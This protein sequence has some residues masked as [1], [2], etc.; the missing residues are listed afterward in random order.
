MWLPKLPGMAALLLIC[1]SAAG[2][3][4][5]TH[6]FL[7]FK[8][9]WNKNKKNEFVI[10]GLA[11]STLSGLPSGGAAGNPGGSITIDPDGS[12]HPHTGAADSWNKW[13]D[14]AIQSEDG[15]IQVL[16][17]PRENIEPATYHFYQTLLPDAQQRKQQLQDYKID[18][19]KDM[20]MGEKPAPL[21]PAKTLADVVG[22]YCKQARPDYDQVMNFYKDHIKGHGNDLNSPPPP[23]FEYSCYACD[24]NL[25]KVYDTTIEHY[26]RDFLHPE[27]NIIRK[28][29]DILH[30]MAL[31]GL[32]PGGGVNVDLYDALFY[33]NK[34]DPSGSGACAYL[35]VSELYQ[36]V[37]ETLH[38]LY[39][40]AEKL[41][42]TNNKNFKAASAIIR[43]YITV[44]R[45][46]ELLSGSETAFS[47]IQ[48]E[49]A[50]LIKRNIDF[51]FD[52]FK[53]NDWRTI[54]NIPFILS[55]YREEGMFNEGNDQDF[56]E[57]LPQLQ[58]ICN[59]FKLSIE[60]DIKIGQNG[61]Y[62]LAHVKGDCHIMPYFMQ[63]SNQCYKWVVA[64]EDNLDGLG[65][66]KPSQKQTIDCQLI[67]NELI[68]PPNAPKPVYIGTRKYTTELRSLSM[69]F[70][71][72]GHDTIMLTGFT[73]NPKTAGTF[74][75]PY[76]PPQNMGLG[77][78]ESFFEDVMAKKR[79]AEDGE[80][81]QAA[82]EV[83]EQ[84]EDLKRQAEALQA[85]M[86]KGHDAA[87]LE[88]L[89]EL[90]GKARG[91]TTN[92]VVGKL[93]YLDFL[94]PVQNNNSVLIDKVYD[95]KEV[96][97]KLAEVVVYGR[98]TVHIEN[99]GNGKTKKPA[100]K[101]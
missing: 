57:Y 1:A 2:Q 58:K 81:R 8:G 74:Q 4:S 100:L 29:L 39:Y 48:P 84:G 54:G 55:L 85:Q 56:Q 18:P 90:A 69:D 26:V 25:R 65:F 28:G 59:G 72:P 53:H 20:L 87:T 95:A 32:E 7:W 51:Y 101:K 45:E 99:N 38:H 15:F 97:P 52:A 62:R 94:L 42:L 37:F 30:N 12:L 46:W 83:K 27:D 98:Y 93:M 44:A 75:L 76:V 47:S 82:G 80:A 92:A 13:V 78:L 21:P 10:E 31:I 79:L 34:K 61:G 9:H 22:D 64:D 66:Y 36:A 67:N 49:L 16:S 41:V 19:A 50:G 43:T 70:C 77:G 11:D 17:D 33:H 73:P 71:H 89:R 68:V 60:M 23:A 96:N 35:S 5:D 40:R 91:M 6:Y 24:S 86:G 3:T 63:D 14:N 88:K